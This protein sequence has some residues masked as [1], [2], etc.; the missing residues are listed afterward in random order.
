MASGILSCLLSGALLHF[1]LEK[2]FCIGYPCLLLFNVFG[3]SSLAC[4]FI[5]VVAD[6][7][8]HSFGSCRNYLHRPRI[9]SPFLSPTCQ[10]Y[11]LGGLHCVAVERHFK[12]FNEL[13]LQ[14]IWRHRN[15]FPHFLFTSTTFTLERPA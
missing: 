6:L 11:I 14:R 10:L 2:A 15:F 1:R 8:N 12:R 13:N 5:S 9:I 4:S 3:V 7:D